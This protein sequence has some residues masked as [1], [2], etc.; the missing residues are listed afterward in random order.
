MA[1]NSPFC[2]CPRLN[3]TLHPANHDKGYSPC[4]EKNLKTGE[5][6]SCY[7]NLMRQPERRENDSILAY[8]K[9]VLEEAEEK[10]KEDKSM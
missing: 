6:P 7:F 10:Q 8:A 9:A 3:C 1:N 5:I 2:T 4:I